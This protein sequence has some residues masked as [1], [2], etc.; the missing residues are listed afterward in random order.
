MSSN[1]VRI[2]VAFLFQLAGM[3]V[4]QRVDPVVFHR[5]FDAYRAAYKRI[6]TEYRDRPSAH[7][8][9]GTR[10][11]RADPFAALAEPRDGA[12]VFA[13]WFTR[14]QAFS[15]PMLIDLLCLCSIRMVDSAME[16]GIP[17]LFAGARE[18]RRYETTETAEIF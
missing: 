3:K 18:I 9:D 14:N 11:Y 15:R 6:L 4:G 12:K 1:L 13:V 8:P 5:A 17:C 10:A 16:A 2:D 7:N